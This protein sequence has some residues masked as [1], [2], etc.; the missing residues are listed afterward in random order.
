MFFGQLEM[1]EIGESKRD[2]GMDIV[3]GYDDGSDAVTARFSTEK[4]G[5]EPCTGPL[6]WMN[7]ARMVLEPEEDAIH[8]C[9]SIDDPRG[10]LVFTIRRLRDG[11]LVIHTPHPD[12]GA[13]HCEVG[14]LH[15]GTMEIGSRGQD[16]E[17]APRTFE[18]EEPEED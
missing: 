12:G 16:G 14:P 10:A 5:G 17:F 4:E 8:L 13:Q 6:S 15:P 11:R 18:D 2:C 9:V 1:G 3:E 7:S